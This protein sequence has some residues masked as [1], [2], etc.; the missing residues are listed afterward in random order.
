MPVR[1]FRLPK[2]AS[3]IPFLLTLV[4]SPTL[5]N[6]QIAL[7][8]PINLTVSSNPSSLAVGDLNRDG[9]PDVVAASS[10]GN[11]IHVMINKGAGAF[12]AP[13]VI[14]VGN[15]PSAVV[16]ADLTG[17]G[18]LDIAVANNGS[19]NITVLKGAVSAGNVSYT[20]LASPV[21]P[22][23]PTGLAAGD[24]DDDGVTDLVACCSSTTSTVQILRN[25]G[26]G[27]F[28]Q[29][30]AYTIASMPTCVTL[31]DLNNDGFL[32]VATSNQSS[33]VSVLLNNGDGTL[34]SAAKITVG[35]VQYWIVSSDVNDDGKMDLLTADNRKNG[36]QVLLGNG[37]GTFAAP[38]L[39]SAGTYACAVAV[40][41]MN[42]DGIKDVVMINQASANIITFIGNGDG[43]FQ[44]P[45]LV[46]AGASH[47]ALALADFNLDGMTDVLAA[48]ATGS[49][50]LL[51]NETSV[52]KS[53]VFEPPV[54]GVG[55]ATM[56]TITLSL[57][58]PAGDLR[59]EVSSSNPA[60]VKPTTPVLV[61]AGNNSSSVALMGLSPGTAEIT[62]SLNGLS[63]KAVL[64]VVPATGGGDGP[65]S[66]VNRDGG[67]DL[68]DVIAVA[69]IAA[70]I[71]AAY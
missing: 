16:V 57:A 48:N 53:V 32:D 12:A 33:S 60:V 29:P 71:D 37:N 31:A 68:R 66:D 2:S 3:F 52:V 18:I 28:G 36:V 22:A 24:M 65:R 44:A 41:D 67:I 55:G 20:A 34:G 59:V 47:T 45:T 69:R 64:T 4:F 42:T 8:S 61:L 7:S 6:A 13:I 26:T 50:T 21:L 46:T 27:T 23:P 58:A 10:G 5:C 35:M 30:V 54:I 17:D 38:K 15:T 25:N 56:M 39:Y 9:K 40:G 1:L 62:A 43:T 14:S 51:L 63:C 70:G 11:S 19:K 49:L